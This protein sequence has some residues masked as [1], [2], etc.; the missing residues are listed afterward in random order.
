MFISQKDAIQHH[1]MLPYIL[2]VE[3]RIQKN[4][5]LKDFLTKSK[6]LQNNSGMIGRLLQINGWQTTVKVEQLDELT[7]LT[8][9]Q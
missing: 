7:L 2:K 9:I 5:Y 6:N 1:Y 4:E 8:F 3:M